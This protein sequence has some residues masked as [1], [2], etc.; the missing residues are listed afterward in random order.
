MISRNSKSYNDTF[1]DEP[2]YSFLDFNEEADN[3]VIQN[4]FW[5]NTIDDRSPYEVGIGDHYWSVSFNRFSQIIITL[6]FYST[7]R[8]MLS[9][10][11]I[12]NN[13]CKRPRGNVFAPALTVA[14][15]LKNVPATSGIRS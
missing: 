15:I 5:S 1:Q 4:L 8:K 10:M 6:Q 12:L 3:Q 13:T 9:Q 11:I 14:S 2:L 7:P